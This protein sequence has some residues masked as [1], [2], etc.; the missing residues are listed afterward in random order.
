MGRAKPTGCTLFLIGA[1]DFVARSAIAPIDLLTGFI[2]LKPRRL[3][4]SD[5]WQV[6]GMDINS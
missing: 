5:R 3:I 6:I 1:N 4:G 2:Y